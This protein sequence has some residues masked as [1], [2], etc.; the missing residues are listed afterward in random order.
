MIGLQTRRCVA[1]HKQRETALPPHV[2]HHHKQ[3]A[4]LETNKKHPFCASEPFELSIARLDPPCQSAVDATHEQ[5][6][7][8]L[9]DARHRRL[10][11]M[12][13]LRIAA[14]EYAR[15]F[16]QPAISRACCKTSGAKR[17]VAHR[18]PCQTREA[19]P[20]SEPA[21][22]LYWLHTKPRF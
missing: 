22:N 21:C 6:G 2:C 7:S 3:F 18:R 11:Q 12:P 20:D 17:V 10:V 5:L 19:R 14:A 1:P 15:W 16:S 4:K 8:E 13:F 9:C